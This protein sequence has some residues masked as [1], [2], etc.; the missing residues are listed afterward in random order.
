ML[1]VLLMPGMILAGSLQCPLPNRSIPLTIIRKTADNPKK[2][3]IEASQ[4]ESRQMTRFFLSGNPLLISDNRAIQAET[5][6]FDQKTGIARARS[7]AILASPDIELKGHSLTMNIHT[8]Q[9]LIHDADYQLFSR[10]GRG[11]A[12][13]ALL[14]DPD[15]SVMKSATFTTCDKD[16]DAWRLQT[17]TLE[18]DQSSDLGKAWNATIW[19]G[20]IP[21]MYTPYID[22][23]LSGKRKSGFLFPT[24]GN[25]DRYGSMLSIPYYLNLAPNYDATVTPY[26]YE[27]RGLGI[28]STIRTLTS[29]QR[30]VLDFFILP[31]DNL[32]NDTRTYAH[33]IQ[34]GAISDQL[35]F[36]LDASEVSDEAYFDDFGS[37]L[38]I[39]SQDWLK[40][41]LSLSY[42]HNRLSASILFEHYSMVDTNL[43]PP[44]F[45]LPDASI[46]WNGS[47]PISQNLSTRWTRFDHQNPESKTIG[48]RLHLSW[49][50]DYR[51]SR[52]W[53]FLHPKLTAYGSHYS[54]DRPG[55]TAS[56]EQERFIPELSVDS[57]IFLE[58]NTALG[59]IP[60]LQTLEPRIFWA[61][62]P[63]RDQSDIPVF[64]TGVAAL[65]MSQL[66]TP[67]RFTGPD[68]IGD[69]HQITTA[70]TSRLFHNSSG[71]E[72]FYMTLGE[73]FYLEDRQVSLSGNSLQESTNS[74]TLLELSFS[75]WQGW[76]TR[77]RVSSDDKHSYLKSSSIISHYQNKEG[78]KIAFSRT[79]QHSDKD[80]ISADDASMSA[81]W[82]ATPHWQFVG[83]WHY[84]YLYEVPRETFAGLQ[85][86]SCC[87]A[88]RLLHRRYRSDILDPESE[89]DS[90][91]FELEL[92]GLGSAGKNITSIIESDILS[93]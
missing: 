56:D 41:H 63:Y 42:S 47:T 73:I 10:K 12:R 81:V 46:S 25:D 59:S 62:I 92:E 80:V 18:M 54:L 5:I 71:F 86:Q 6:E 87:W 23:S 57:G 36:S 61:Y 39:V 29:W 7:E 72:Y 9:G 11:H 91:M 93:F 45:R 83:K 70:V 53:G 67:N 75:P 2:V 90:I 32:Y 74:G 37:D 79:Q 22:F 78:L 34:S 77:V 30:S 28:F 60:L 26:L 64:D 88:L 20:G 44:Y 85:Y 82:P 89:K 8:S 69:T 24:Y 19:L 68:R 52:Q 50:A 58:R 13:Q 1:V 4:I 31:D 40:N 35:S 48:D 3:L 51:F 76:Q 38:S 84:S 66:F 27:R 55:Q 65:S 16:S 43:S 17:S 21:V 33:F 49:S 15:N 14:L